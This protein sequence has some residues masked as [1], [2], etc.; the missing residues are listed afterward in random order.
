MRMDNKA[1]LAVV[2]FGSPSCAHAPRAQPA[3]RSTILH[4]TGDY[5]DPVR[6]RTTPAVKNF[7]DLLDDC[8]HVIV[9]IKRYSRKSD[10]YR[11][12]FDVGPGRRVIALGYQALP[13]GLF[14][15][16]T[17]ARIAAEISSII[18]ESPCCAGSRCRAQ[19]D[20]RRRDRLSAAA[21]IGTALHLLRAGRGGGQV[22]PIQTG[23]QSALR[24]SHR[25][26]RGALLCLGLVQGQRI[27]KTYPGLPRRQELLPNFSNLP[28]VKSCAPPR[29]GHVFV[30]ALD[31][32]MYRRKGF[33]HLLAALVEARKRVP[34]LRLDVIGW[35]TPA[36]MDKLQRL[37]R[38]VGAATAVQFLGVLPHEGVLRAIPRYGAM[39]LPAR[40]ETFGMV[41]VEALLSGVPILY[42][43]GSGIDGYL[44]DLYVGTPVEA[45][46]VKAIAEGLCELALGGK[47]YRQNIVGDYETLRARFSPAPYLRNFRELVN[48]VRE[49]SASVGG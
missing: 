29:D 23:T 27:E 47:R 19:A 36:T 13:A 1:N 41:Y 21:E 14:H 3:R 12:E 34:D 5:P 11:R 43:A 31:L 45:G 15:R 16:R 20:H 30:T 37:V 17:M 22:F 2:D 24:R 25:A 9:S 35:S 32:D 18:S 7:I 39:V 49:R 4:I 26:I 42:T 10:C 44:D 38:R 6:N 28:I 40:N 33:H 8:D 48:A 46:N